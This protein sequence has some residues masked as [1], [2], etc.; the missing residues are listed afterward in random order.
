MGPALGEKLAEA[1]LGK[2]Q[3][4]V[5]EWSLGRFSAGLREEKKWI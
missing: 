1:V 4:N 3:L 5:P 2:R